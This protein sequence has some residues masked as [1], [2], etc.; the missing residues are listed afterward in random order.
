MRLVILAGL[1]TLASPLASAV[2]ESP[3][4]APTSSVWTVP[5]EGCQ[6]SPMIGGPGS[7]RAVVTWTFATGVVTYS[8]DA[9]GLS[10]PI[11]AAHIHGPA[12]RGAAA[13]PIV[14]L[15]TSLPGSGSF[16]PDPA[17]LR[18]LEDGQLYINLHTA[19]F[20]GGELR[21]QIDGL[22][23]ACPPPADAGSD[24]PR[25]VDAGVS[26]DDDDK[27]CHGCAGSSAP[28]LGVALIALAL[29]RRRARAG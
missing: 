10:A 5:L 7:G 24:A 28:S 1:V 6:E 4:D 27:G 23:S 14:A 11:T 9:F 3:P 18:Q 19:A 13:P 12:A 26:G 22:G 20:P 21:G 8:I 17:T 16:S 25:G 2:A 29:R 15:P